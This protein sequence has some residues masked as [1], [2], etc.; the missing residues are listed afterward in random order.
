[1]RA[2]LS[3]ATQRR[4]AALFKFAALR[5]PYIRLFSGGFVFCSSAARDPH[6]RHEVAGKTG[7][8]ANR[9]WSA[10]IQFSNWRSSSPGRELAPVSVRIAVHTGGCHWPWGMHLPCNFFA[11]QVLCLLSLLRVELPD[12]HNSIKIR[13]FP[14]QCT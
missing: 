11:F 8:C 5:C 2:L 4:H 7:F 3:P 6:L 12:S 14:L 10:V 1:M 9:F 13:G